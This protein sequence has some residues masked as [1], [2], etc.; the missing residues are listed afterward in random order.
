MPTARSSSPAFLAQR[1]VPQVNTT[2]K[3]AKGVGD[4]RDRSIETDKARSELSASVTRR[5][6]KPVDLSVDKATEMKH[7]VPTTRVRDAST[8]PI[9]TKPPEKLTENPPD[10]QTGQTLRLTAR[11]SK[12]KT[13]LCQD[14]LAKK[15]TRTHSANKDIAISSLLDVAPQDEMASKPAKKSQRQLLEER[16]AKIPKKSTLVEDFSPSGAASSRGSG[17]D[18]SKDRP[19]LAKST[20]RPQ[21]AGEDNATALAELDQ[22]IMP[23]D[24]PSIPEPAPRAMPPP[25]KQDRHLRKV[26]SDVPRPSPR[27][28]A[29]GAPMRFTP[30]PSRG[31][32]PSAASAAADGEFGRPTTALPPKARGK[33]PIQRSVSLNTTANGTSAVIFSKPFQ[34]PK[35]P[36][37]KA[38]ESQK[39]PDPWSREAFDLF[40][41]RPPGWDEEKWCRGGAQ[42]GEAGSP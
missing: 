36:A 35:A 34:T 15:A 3:Q 6:P 14:Q 23:P 12:K 7:D 13:L 28:R 22:M 32:Q 38:T 30:S 33:K 10:H 19:Q 5:H 4:L 20:S 16:L 40:T 31:A 9:H 21:T 24:E 37:L 11:S 8:T 42:A 39:A 27:K 1:A 2:E 26:V 41:W 29:P 17:I 25:L 18:P